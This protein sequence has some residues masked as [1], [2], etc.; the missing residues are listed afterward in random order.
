[1]LMHFIITQIYPFYNSHTANI[2][3]YALVDT[4]R[5]KISTASNNRRGE[6]NRIYIAVGMQYFRSGNNMATN[7]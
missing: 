7:L 1:M 2:A 4:D 6:V 5:C 3:M